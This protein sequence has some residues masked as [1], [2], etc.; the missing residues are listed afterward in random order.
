MNKSNSV[1]IT[2]E[3]YEYFLYASSVKEGL[4]DSLDEFENGNLSSVDF[5]KEIKEMLEM[6]RDEE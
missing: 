1:L 2:K 6:E 3:T 5:L 4:Q